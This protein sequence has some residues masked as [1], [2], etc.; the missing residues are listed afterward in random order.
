MKHAGPSALDRLEPVLRELRR[1]PLKEK[2][3]GAFYRAGKAFLHFHEDRALLFADLRL[4]N[5]FERL[6]ATTK[7]ERTALLKKVDGALKRA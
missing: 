7:D 1:H 6:P 4:K 5:D 2:S 3:R